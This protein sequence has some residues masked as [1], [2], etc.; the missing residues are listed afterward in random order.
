MTVPLD[1]AYITAENNVAV[2]DEQAIRQIVARLNHALDAADYPL[3][4]SFFSQDAVLI[5]LLVERLDKSKSPQP[6]NNRDHSSL[7]NVMR[8]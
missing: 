6:S 1:T 3:Y 8:L 7:T 2:A 4:A 5:R